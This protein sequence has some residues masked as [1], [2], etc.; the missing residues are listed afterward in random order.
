MFRNKSRN[1]ARVRPAQSAAAPAEQINSAAAIVK[2]VG[3][4]PGCTS[5]EIVAA[6]I[7]MPLTDRQTNI[8]LMFRV[9]GMLKAGFIASAD[10][11]HYN[12][13]AS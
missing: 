6:V 12:L 11:K 7:R 5:G 2:F 9:Q 8:G 1:S 4:H 10:G 13:P 3:E